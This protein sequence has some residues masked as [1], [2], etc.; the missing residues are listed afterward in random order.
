M[1]TGDWDDDAGA[2][3][4]RRSWFWMRAFKT[5][6]ALLTTISD[7]FFGRDHGA[8]GEKRTMSALDHSHQ[9]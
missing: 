6:T 3:E 4:P 8:V 1:V 7:T 5:N 9:G 2:E